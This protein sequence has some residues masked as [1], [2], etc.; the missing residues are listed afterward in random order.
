MLELAPRSDGRE[1]GSSPVPADRLHQ[2]SGAAS[3]C[4]Q[5]TFAS[6]SSQ[7]DVLGTFFNDISDSDAFAH[8]HQL[9]PRYITYSASTFAQISYSV[10]AIHT[11]AIILPELFSSIFNMKISAQ[12]YHVITVCD[13]FNYFDYWA[14]TLVPMHLH[15]F[16]QKNPAAEVIF[17][18]IPNPHCLHLHERHAFMSWASRPFQSFSFHTDPLPQLISSQGLAFQFSLFLT[19]LSFLTLSSMQR[20]PSFIKSNY[21]FFFL[22][23]N[24]HVTK[25]RNNVSEWE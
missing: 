16:P 25:Y 7:W 5:G 1:Y 12:V 10:C 14:W 13:Y 2:S 3:Q 17:Y 22:F 6:F 11:N 4:A 24:L 19:K 9:P 15:C 20:M 23:Y 21:L 8:L 18:S